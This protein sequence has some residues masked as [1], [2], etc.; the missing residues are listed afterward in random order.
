MT[1]SIRGLALS[2][3]LGTT[4]LA[5]AAFADCGIAAGKVSIIGNDFPAIHTVTDAAAACATGTVEVKANLTKD[6]EKLNAPG[7]TA[8]PAEYSSAIVASSSIVP[9]MGAGLLRP[10]DD[11]IA[12]HG[13]DIP[14]GQLITID[15]KVMAVAFMAN[16]QHMFIRKD[17]LEAAGAAAP[18]TYDELL[19]AAEKVRAGGMASPFC[20]TYGVGWNL[21]Q[22][23]VN[24]YLGM[25]GEFFKPGS[26]EPAVNNEK[27]VAA[28][29]TMKALTGYMNPDF[30]TFDS[31]AVT[32][33]WEAGNCAIATLWGSRA[34][35][36]MDGK[37]SAPG[38][39]EN[40]VAAA[41][42][43]AG[44]NSFP[45]TTLWW[46]GWTVATN[47]SDEDAAATFMAM[48]AGIA[49]SILTA[50]TM[51][52]AVWMIEGYQPTAAAQGVAESI[53]GGAPS[54]PMEPYMGAMHMA[55]DGN[56]AD[57]LTGKED[58]AT[59]LADIEAAYIAAAKE[60]GFLK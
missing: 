1:T 29:E 38:V 9:L 44:G 10:L 11:L 36:L 8:K 22:E 5:G 40:T 33:E 31:N 37:E 49:P 39:A 30:L 34:A 53:A 25:G 19:A 18:K 35:V 2:G 3:L 6:H 54:Y 13:T 26:A 7:M 57:F 56:L 20:S 21:G 41:T 24:M 16:A 55:A 17:V 43:S 47:V 59:A 42:P 46:D 28:L 51:G 27:G 4:M 45:A 14:K 12:A 52:Q 50:N 32:A 48:K 23:F 58:A 60:G 15:G